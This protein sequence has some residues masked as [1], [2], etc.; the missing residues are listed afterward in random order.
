MVEIRSQGMCRADGKVYEKLLVSGLGPKS[1]LRVVVDPE[2]VPAPLHALVVDLGAEEQ[3]ARVFVGVCD[4]PYGSSGRYV[5]AETDREGRVLATDVREVDFERAKWESRVNYRVRRSLCDQIRLCDQGLSDDGSVRLSVRSVVPAPTHVIYRLTYRLPDDRPAKVRALVVND[6]L[7]AVCTAP[8]FMGEGTVRLADGASFARE[9]QLSV[10]VPWNQ[11]V[12][13]LYA[14]DAER[15]GTLACEVVAKERADALVEQATRELFVN[16]G[17]DPYYKEWFSQQRPTEHELGLQRRATL[18]EMP[19][20]SLIVPLFRTPAGFFS[21]ML[22]SVLAQSY[23]RWEL[24]LVNASP[25]MEGLCRQVE[26]ACARDARVRSVTLERNLGI[27]ENTNA[28]IAVA[29]G[30]FV[31]F[32]DH[33]DVIEPNLL[34]EYARAVSERPD[35]DVLYCDEDKIDEAGELSSPFFKPAFGIDDLRGYNVVCHL[36]CIRR[37]L[38]DQLEPNTAEFDGAQDHNLTLEAA[39]RARYVNHVPRMLYHW[40]ATASSTA[41]NADSKPYA[42]EAGMRAVRAHLDSL[43]GGSYGAEV[44]APSSVDYN[45]DTHTVGK[46]LG[47]EILA[48]LKSLGLYDRGVRFRTITGDGEEAYYYEDGSRGDYYGIIRYARR[49]GIPGIIVEHAFIDNSGDYNSFLSSDAKLKELGVADAE[50][51]ASYYGLTKAVESDFAPVYD[52]SYYVANNKEVASMGREE[53]FRHF[54]VTG[55]KKGLQASASFSPSFYKNNNA[56]LRFKFGSL[57]AAYYYHYLKTGKSEGRAG[58]G[59]A[60]AVVTLWRLYNPYTGEHFYTSSDY[61]RN[62]NVYQGWNY[63][64]IGWEAPTE[65]KQVYRLYNRYVKGG[66]HHYT[67]DTHERDELVKAGWT[68]EKDAATWCSGGD[69]PLYRQYNPYATTGTHNYTTNAEERDFLIKEGWR[70]EKIAW[71]GVYGGQQA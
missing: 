3:G 48:E 66:D 13:Y 28:G 24:V 44:W 47:N 22:E 11:R 7:E 15:P 2:L 67:M 9:V 62:V 68:Y 6:A 69:V 25:E 18:P 35:T 8:V 14:W 33:D 21:E 29:T 64:G 65:G 56:D 42:A 54:L 51:I 27:S 23:Q 10:R 12:A 45:N 58:T 38:L 36:L 52:Y 20:F 46:D 17:V 41:G 19:L 61:E 31:G 59:S 63:E 37:T 53:A 55:M 57:M 5:I 70:D 1:C 39:E 49:A 40:R 4:I 50:G 60:T 34:F 16:A 43:N 26:E 71:Y 30:D 32:F